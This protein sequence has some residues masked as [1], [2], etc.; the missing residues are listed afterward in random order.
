MSCDSESSLYTPLFEGLN[1]I[2]KWNLE[3]NI[4]V[5]REASVVSM[6]EPAPDTMDAPIIM[7]VHAR[8]EPRRWL[9]RTRPRP[10]LLHELACQVPALH[11]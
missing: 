5:N 10:Q 11:N 7:V 4:I 2:Y 9:P 6:D 3:S 8:R 1:C